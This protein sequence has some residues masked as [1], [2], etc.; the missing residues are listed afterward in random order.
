MDQAALLSHNIGPKRFG[1]EF[2]DKDATKQKSVKRSAFSLN[3]ARPSVNEGLGENSTG[4]A[5]Q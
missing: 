5:V 2:G 4:K 3:P 1:R